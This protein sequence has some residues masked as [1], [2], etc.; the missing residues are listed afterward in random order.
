MTRKID[1]V[2]TSEDMDHL[3]SHIHATRDSTSSVKVDKAV[4]TR[5]LLVHGQLLN[6]YEKGS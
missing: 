6:H 2:T 3:W 4:L 5:L 1:T